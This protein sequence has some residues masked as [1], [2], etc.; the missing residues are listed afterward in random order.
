MQKLSLV[1]KLGFVAAIAVVCS[2]SLAQIS[3]AQRNGGDYGDG[4]YPS[5]TPPSSPSPPQPPIFL[6]PPS[7]TAGV[8]DRLV[9]TMCNPVSP[10]PN[11][12]IAGIDTEQT[13]EICRYTKTCTS[14]PPVT[15]A[16]V[17]ELIKKAEQVT[18]SK[19]AVVYFNIFADRLEILVVPANGK[20]LRKVVSNIGK[21]KSAVTVKDEIEATVVELLN[22]IRDP[23][24]EDYLPTAQSLY[25]WLI[26]PIEADLESSEIKTLVFVMAG[27][28]RSI[29]ISVLHDGKKFLAQKYA[30]A[31]V[32]SMG[33][34]NLQLRDRRRNNILAMGLTQK[35]QEF[36]EIPNVAIE[37]N[38]IIAQI[39]EGKVF[40][41]Q[42]FTLENLITQQQQKNY[43]IVHLATHAQFLSSTAD[44]AFIQ[45][46]NERLS[47]DRLRTI[48]IGQEAIEMLVLSA[49][50]TAVGQNLGLSGVAII[51]RAKSVLAS[52]WK[53][54]D[55]GTTPLMLAF[56][57]NYPTAKSKAIAIQ[58][59]QIALIEGNVKIENQKV[60]G[61]PNL[62]PILLKDFNE[63]S[64]LKHPYFWSSFILVGNWL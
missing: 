33:L 50:Q 46:W 30:T 61:I 10:Q 43:G 35:T 15:L 40:L 36:S 27:S 45:L 26:R 48:Q 12:P 32:P 51:Y 11:E 5:P 56:Y 18:E 21:N 58:Q 47:L 29:P 31:T 14:I 63:G 16:F 1:W 7:S 25:D 59:A 44:G 39:L 60:V 28:L 17:Q 20:E 53:V 54:D 57:H 41:N 55:A 23:S 52:L 37:V 64:E 3:T 49:C 38:T 62:P 2:T 4:D 9:G 13:E 34:V 24:S 42:D 19:T 22:A 8:C 6:P